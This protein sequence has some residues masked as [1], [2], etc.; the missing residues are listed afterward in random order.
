MANLAIPILVP[1]LEF[2]FCGGFSP[3]GGHQGRK[4]GRTGTAES[5]SLSLS[6]SCSCLT[7]PDQHKLKL[8][9]PV[10]KKQACPQWKHSFTFSGVSPSQLRQSSLEL[11]VWDQA[12]FGVNDRLLGAA[13]LGSSK[14]VRGI[15]W[16]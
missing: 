1:G 5:G 6:L 8:K 16:A 10:V 3:S 14:S 11:T 9:S 2:F 15:Y 12:I 13:R 4:P 7:L